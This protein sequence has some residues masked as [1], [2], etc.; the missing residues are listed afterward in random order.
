[1]KGVRFGAALLVALPWLR[2][3]IQACRCLP[4]WLNRLIDE[5]F[6]PLCHHMAGRVLV[7]SGQPMCVCSRCA[8]LYAG[9]AVGFLVG[10][11]RL[12]GRTYARMVVVA[13]AAAVVDVVTQDAGLHAPYHPARLAT[14]ALLG[15]TT[16]AWMGQELQTRASRELTAGAGSSPLASGS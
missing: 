14:G 2:A 9:L 15:W 10:G 4:D 13:I 11:P 7:L 6:R 12:E 5:A 1:M 8:G 3:W 16:A